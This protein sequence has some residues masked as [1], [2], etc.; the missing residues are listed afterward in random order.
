MDFNF[1]LTQINK[2]KKLPLGGQESQFKMAPELRKQFSLKDVENR[3]PRPSAVLALFYP[4]ENNNTRFLL[5]LRSTYK[6]VHA[7]Q[8]SFPGGKKDKVDVGLVDTALRETE[9][10]IG[11]DKNNITI[12]RE[13]TKTYIPPS[14]FWVY[15]FMGYTDKTPSFVSNYEVEILIEVLVSDLIN[16]KSL[17]TKNLTTSYMENID[18]P[19]FKLN[20]YIVWGAT[21]MMLSEIK[22]LFKSIKS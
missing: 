4:D 18:V 14:N 2:L 3:N 6:G 8:I 9:E 7:A 21:A 12:L 16:E 5:T 19:C 13:M 1:F 17:S 15:P 10:E 20:G 22:D 11:V